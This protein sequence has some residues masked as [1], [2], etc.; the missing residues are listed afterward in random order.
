MVF[1]WCLQDPRQMVSH[2]WMPWADRSATTAITLVAGSLS[3]LT[4]WPGQLSLS[5]LFTEFFPVSTNSCGWLLKSQPFGCSTVSLKMVEKLSAR[6]R[7]RADHE[8][9]ALR[10]GDTEGL[11]DSGFL[12]M[13]WMWLGR[14]SEGIS[15]SH[16]DSSHSLRLCYFSIVDAGWP[17]PFFLF[18]KSS[19]SPSSAHRF[20]FFL[21]GKNGHRL[22]LSLSFLITSGASFY[23][24]IS[25]SRKSLH[26]LCAFPAGGFYWCSSAS[27]SSFLHLCHLCSV[28]KTNRIFTKL[29]C[30][31]QVSIPK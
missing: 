12:P 14:V 10:E 13:Q 19:F 6:G 15:W 4:V 31:S 20:F 18:S 29:V 17:V 3:Q 28:F 7:E 26:I 21:R 2:R 22:I 8:R 5:L 25:N 11:H 24:L 30:T 1:C 23:K 9:G 27:F 16:C